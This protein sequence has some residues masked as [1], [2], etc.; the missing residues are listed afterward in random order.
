MNVAPKIF[1][2]DVLIGFGVA[3]DAPLRHALE[4]L[5]KN[6][7]GIALVVDA[8]RRFQG[9]VTDGDIR[10]AILQGVDFAIPVMDYLA[11]KTGPG[12]AR[13][14]TS[15]ADAGQ[16]EWVRLMTEHRVRHL[17]LVDADSRV[18]GLVLMSQLARDDE[19]PLRAVV[20]AGGYGV[21]L[22]PLTGAT[23]KPLL[24]V[25][26]KPLMEHIIG[27]LRDSGVRRVSIT[28]HFRPEKIRDHFG[29]G[30]DFGI[31]V[32]YTHEDKPLGTAGAL[33][34]LR[35]AGE[36]LLVVNGDILT[37]VDFRAML[38]FH[39]DQESRLTV[40]VRK[41]EVAVPFGVIEADGTRVTRLVE[42]P[43]LPFFI[44]A[45]VYLVEPGVVDAI[46]PDRKVDMTDIIE[47]LIRQGQTVTS[48][49]IHE[50]WMDIGR[51]EDY[52]RASE[53]AA[54]GKLGK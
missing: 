28:T 51:V 15:T 16:A 42:K 14:L 47:D 19:L 50:Y 46:P 39:R 40:G 25:G 32:Q 31:D 10:R 34:M 29:D 41:Y 37:Q 52:L 35:G 8:E 7:E 11:H 2:D 13:P 5:E 45:G 4:V 23:P 22:K 27:Q 54:T 53:D 30:S 33:S 6:G 3:P 18:A 24:P 26:D 12:P 38:D 1:V 36:P 17:P 44:N 49:P 9:L 48:F 20:M 21:R 43:S